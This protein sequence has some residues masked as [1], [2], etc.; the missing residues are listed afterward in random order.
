LPSELDALILAA[1]YDRTGDTGPAAA[2]DGA[3]SEWA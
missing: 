1:L 2:V 3:F